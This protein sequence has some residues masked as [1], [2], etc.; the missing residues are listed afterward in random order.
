MRNFLVYLLLLAI[1]G[2]SKIFYRHEVE[3][4]D[5]PRTDPWRDL[6][7]IALLHHTS[8][9]EPIFAAAAPNR[10]LREVALHGVVPVARKTAA[11]PLVGTFFRLVAGHVIPI[12]RE[13]DHTWEEVCRRIRDPSAVLVILPEGRMMRR[14]GLDA[15]GN[16]MT[17]RGGIAD[18]LRTVPGGRMLLAYSGGL[19]HVHAPGDRF[20]RPFRRVRLRLEVLEIERYRREL[21]RAAGEEGFKA[22]VVEDLTRRRDRHCPIHDV[23][24][25]AA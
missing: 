7:V 16:P 6:R 8:L 15:H 19:H 25:A 17:V 11:R 23:A 24:G 12:T 1:K 20:P 18:I 21:L 10:L 5:P 3:W 9:Y 2:L 22:A 14:T 13:R 4:V